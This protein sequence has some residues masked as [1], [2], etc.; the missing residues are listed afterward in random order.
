MLVLSC[1]LC[2]AGI[3]WI[4]IPN[5]FTVT[6][7][8]GISMVIQERTGLNYAMAYYVITFIIAA[9]ALFVLGIEEMKN[10]LFL[11]VLYPAVLWVMNLFPVEIILK[12]KLIAVA[13]F[14]VLYGGGA[15][16]VLREG[17]TFGGMDTL[18]KVLKKAVFRTWEIR[19]IM[20]LAD[21]LI[22]FLMLSVFSLDSVAYAFVGQ[23]VTVNSMN[24]VLFNIGAKLYEVQIISDHSRELEQFVI[25]QIHKSLTIHPV[26]GSYSG[27]S[28]IQMDCV[29]TSK[30]YVKLREFLLEHDRACFIK[31]L[32]LVH[33]FGT[34]KDFR[35][36]D[37]NTI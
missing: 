15:G 6:G 20:L 24:Y 7:I 9:A 14:G 19:Y 27:E 11:S 4:A 10:I 8:A 3:N 5:G 23:L 33:V 18:S 32:P 37:D 29:C 17:C 25:S 36:L 30:E 13:L 12:E 26:K 34:N 21:S 1:F 31:V 28:K 2:S 35:K 22:M 16:I